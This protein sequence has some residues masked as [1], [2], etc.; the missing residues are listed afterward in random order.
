MNKIKV[1]ATA[2][3]DLKNHIKAAKTA[4]TRRKKDTAYLKIASDIYAI[5]KGRD[6]WLDSDTIYSVDS[7]LVENAY[8]A[9]KANDR[10]SGGFAGM[11]ARLQ[12]LNH[13]QALL[14]FCELEVRR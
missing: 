6:P 3:D 4:P 14:F 5:R 1:S 13:A 2:L 11:M 9:A 7:S 12:L 8:H 10:D